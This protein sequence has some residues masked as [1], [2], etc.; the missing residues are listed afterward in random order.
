MT[1]ITY[2]TAIHPA[3]VGRTAVEALLGMT[4]CIVAS[5][6][7]VVVSHLRIMRSR[8]GRMTIGAIVVMIVVVIDMMPVVMH[9]PTMERMVPIRPIIPI[10][11]GRIAVP[12]GII[13]EPVVDK[14][15]NVIN[16]FN[17][18]VY[19][20]EILITNDLRSDLIGHFVFLHIDRSYVLEDILSQNGLNENQVF[21]PFGSLYDA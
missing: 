19:A 11:K 20:I 2:T 6:I 3:Y 12:M 1:R 8:M 4:R 10:P 16:G 21:L 9:S 18:I 17:D 14:R 5:T 13:E 7:P 15:S